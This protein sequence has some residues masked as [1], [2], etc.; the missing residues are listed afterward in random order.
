MRSKTFRS[1]REEHCVDR[2]VYG[3]SIRDTKVCGSEKSQTGLREDDPAE[4][5]DN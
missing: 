4:G 3:S 2:K 1:K 5:K